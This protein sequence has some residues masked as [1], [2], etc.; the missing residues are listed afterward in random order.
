MT[1]T[2]R[3]TVRR[4]RRLSDH[5]GSS[6]S[7]GAHPVTATV[8]V[9]APPR[10]LPP[11]GTIKRSRRDDGGYDRR[12]GSP[13]RGLRSEDR[14]NDYDETSL[15]KTAR[16]AG[17]SF[18]RKGAA[19]GGMK[20][21]G[22]VCHGHDSTSV[23]VM[24]QKSGILWTWP[25]LKVGTGEA[26]TGDRTTLSWRPPPGALEYGGTGPAD[27]CRPMSRV[28]AG[29]LEAIGLT[30]GRAWII[31]LETAS[32]D[33]HAPYSVFRFPDAAWL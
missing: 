11:P 29:R 17:A 12:R 8:T 28:A 20:L 9:G 21:R 33:P 14:R 31:R 3:G 5:R 22:Y 6:A 26:P 15:K 1:T 25:S 18:M 19:C 13:V 10:R 32:R 4:R 27:S 24:T 23:A 7:G 2:T 30:G 16:S